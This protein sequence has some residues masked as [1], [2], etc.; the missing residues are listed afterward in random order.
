MSEA[1][2]DKLRKFAERL[3]AYAADS[4]L[5]DKAILRSGMIG[6]TGSLILLH[7]DLSQT[8]EVRQAAGRAAGTMGALYAKKITAAI[9]AQRL[10][11]EAEELR[12]QQDAPPLSENDVAILSELLALNATSDAPQTR[13]TVARRLRWEGEGKRAFDPLKNMGYVKG[14]R[15]DFYLTD[16]GIQRARSLG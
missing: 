16:A 7:N 11:L 10:R 5:V 14:C 3:E 1:I 9:A 4:H 15:S 12:F 8:T 2:A 6:G 13:D